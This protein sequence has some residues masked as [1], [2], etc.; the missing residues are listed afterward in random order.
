M[1][2]ILAYI[3]PKEPNLHQFKK[4]LSTLD[5][6]G[7]DNTSY[8]QKTSNGHYILLGH[9]RLK[10]IDLSDSANQPLKTGGVYLAYNGEIYN[11]KVIRKTLK[12]RGVEFHTQSDTEVLAKTYQHL[13]MERT[14]DSLMGMFAFCLLDS[15]L[16]QIHLVRDHCGIKPL[17]YWFDGESFV[18]ASEVKALLPLLNRSPEIDERAL[19]QFYYHRYVPEPQ[20]IYRDIYAV[21]AGEWLTLEL[22]STLR[23]K[24]NRY[25]VLSTE[26]IIKDEHDAVDRIDELLNESV[27]L[28]LISDVPLA[29]AFSG[30]LDSSLLMAIGRE[31]KR[32]L[33]GFTIERGD[34]SLD[35]IYSR[36]VAKYLGTEQII[37]PFHKIDPLNEDRGIFSYYDQPIACSSI[38]STYLL[39]KEMSKH[40]RVSL[41][42]DGG[43]EIFGGYNWYQRHMN[44]LYLK[45]GRLRKISSIGLGGVKTLWEDFR[46]YGRCETS[47]MYK[48]IL[49]DRFQRQEIEQMLQ[50][51]TN[52]EADDLIK[53]FRP[54][55]ETVKDAMFVDFHTFLRY[56]L[57]RADFSSMMHSM[58]NRV[59]YLNHK[60][61]EFVFSVD[62]ELFVRRGQLKYLLKK[63]AERYLPK[64]L[65]YRPKRGFT[66]PIVNY[67]PVK[68][69]PEFM[70]FILEK[71]FNTHYGPLNNSTDIPPFIKVAN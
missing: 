43:D 31:Y 39:F 19:A 27:E 12:N 4:A 13:G 1:C 8:I 63:V 56:A 36:R 66:V 65:I 62:H 69:G 17:Y 34:D 42:G 37:V 41:S 7:P 18:A 21:D 51:K 55:V 54:E 49:L 50:F 14:L 64:K 10:I 20:T 47:M 6:R 11:Y 61:V 46:R 29:V 59:P 26:N 16:K 23:L 15:D 35:L 58:E 67:L 48:R 32:D 38:F 28:H 71:W 22:G 33:V 52:I 40:F 30:G 45:R 53:K 25:W 2:G 5:K 57:R 3:S 44:L 60:L 68:T 70:R 9:T 24:R